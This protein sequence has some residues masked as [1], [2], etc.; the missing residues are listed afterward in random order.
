MG[1]RTESFHRKEEYM[2]RV[3]LVV[4]TVE[5]IISKELCALGSHHDYHQDV[6]L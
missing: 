6:S 4:L 1:K 3:W 2:E 5:I